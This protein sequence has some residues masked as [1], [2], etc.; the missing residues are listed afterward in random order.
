MTKDQVRKIYLQKRIGLS[1]AEF[2]QLNQKLADTFFSSIDL[3][4]VKVLHT[5]LPIEKQKEVNTWLIIERLKKDFK[6]IRVAVPRINNQTSMLDN[7]YFE[8]MDQLE[9]NTWGILEPKQG[10]PVPTE[11]L[12]IV[13]VPLLGFDK[14]GN[15]VGYGRGFYDK[16]LA[17]CPPTCE[18][19]GLSLFPALNA[20]E[21]MGPNDLPMSKV[22]TPQGC[23]IAKKA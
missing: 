11:Q 3:S 14:F 15:R 9:K 16:F 18:K 2:R 17:T 6:N 8:G 19:I 13:L 7:F 23:V 10:I 22:I 1:E 12:S 5:F 21:G 20:I 4:S